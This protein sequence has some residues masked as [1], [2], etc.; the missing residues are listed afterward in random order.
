MKYHTSLFIVAL[1]ALAFTG[2]SKQSAKHTNQQATNS[3]TIHTVHGIVT[4][5]KVTD[6]GTIDIS[7][8]KASSHVLPNGEVCVITPTILSNNIVRLVTRIDYTNSS[9][10][11]QTMTVALKVPSGDTV[12]FDDPN[13]NVIRL[14]PRILK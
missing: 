6:L 2:C 1:L 4:N 8:G 13:T 14:R 5:H 3:D 9:G 11:K 10:T 7:D 12:F